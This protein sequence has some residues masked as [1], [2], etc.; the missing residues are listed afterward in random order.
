MRR[1]FGAEIEDPAGDETAQDG[2]VG[3][4]DGHVVF[5][6]ADAVVDW[7]GPVRLEECVE[8]IAV[9]EI[10]LCGTDRSDTV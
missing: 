2:N 4:D 9:L 1:R 6:V 10:Y 8:A 7:V 3:Y 5:N